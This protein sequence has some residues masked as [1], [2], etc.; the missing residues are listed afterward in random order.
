MQQGF[1]GCARGGG[2]LPA[3]PMPGAEAALRASSREG[4]ARGGTR[5]F[6]L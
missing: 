6:P 1:V 5:R 3:H 4:A 2:P